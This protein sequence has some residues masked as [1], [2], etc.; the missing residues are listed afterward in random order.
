MRLELSLW[1]CQSEGGTEMASLA[2]NEY[3]TARLRGAARLEDCHIQDSHSL[4]YWLP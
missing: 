1:D 2:A 3:Q 4:S